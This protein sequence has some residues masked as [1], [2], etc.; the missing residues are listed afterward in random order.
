MF[1]LA[2]IGWNEFWQQEAAA[3]NAAVQNVARV[4][5]ENRGVY[6]LQTTDGEMQGLV[7]GKFRKEAKSPANFP[8]VGDWVVIEK[9]PQESKAIIK[10]ILPRKTKLSR[11]YAGEEIEEQIIVT[12]ADLVFVVQGLDHD[13]NLARLERYVALVKEGDAKPVIILNKCDLAQN[14]AEKKDQVQNSLNVETVLLVSAKEKQGLQ[15]IKELLE[16]GETAVFV[17]SSGAGK[18]TLLNALLGEEKQKISE[19]RLDDSRGKHTT[20][21]REL[22]VLPSG[23]VLID[24][25]GMRELGMWATAVAMDETFQDI[26]KLAQ[27]CKFRD[28]D[29]EISQNCAVRMALEKGEINREHYQN[30]LKLKKELNPLQARESKKNQWAQKRKQQQASRRR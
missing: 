22:F 18:S 23:G 16:E 8:K 13:F 21:K 3:R 2:K 11:K 19:V 29:H 9:L 28:C 25:P 6:V 4:V 27:N 10:E 14:A 15:Q 7:R 12:N 5:V 26:E 20:T 24:T 1:D 17:G 30:Y